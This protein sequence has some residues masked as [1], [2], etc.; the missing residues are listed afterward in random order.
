MMAKW[1]PTYVNVPRVDL[2][3]RVERIIESA[4]AVEDE[5]DEA[6]SGQLTF[7]FTPRAL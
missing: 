3:K 5:Q 6:P 2:G 4:R 7:N 1:G